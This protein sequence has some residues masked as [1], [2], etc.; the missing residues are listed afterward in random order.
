MT[1]KAKRAHDYLEQIQNIAFK[2]DSLNVALIEMEERNPAN[3][4]A[5]QYDA[6]KVQT[7]P[8]ADT[9][10][11]YIA[12]QE[13]YQRDLLAIKA[14]YAERQND[15]I[16]RIHRLQNG[17]YVDILTRRYVAGQKWA[18]IAD[19]LNYFLRWTKELGVR[20]IEAFA[21]AN[22]DLWRNSQ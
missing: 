17:L 11:G 6:I 12:A 16:K 2:I 5:I 4:R 22:Q 20:A 9:M 18:D 13:R 7:S 3:I 21:D 1:D 19:D 14:E 15:A 8:N 10:T